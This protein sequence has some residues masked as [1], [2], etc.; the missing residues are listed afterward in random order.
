MGKS[1]KFVYRNRIDEVNHY[2]STVLRRARQK[3]TMKDT[4]YLMRHH[5]SGRYI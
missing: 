3:K 2:R 4:E 1:H 5:D